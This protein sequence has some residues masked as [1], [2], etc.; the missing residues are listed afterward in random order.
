M[1]GKPVVWT[2]TTMDRF[3]LP[4]IVADSGIELERLAGVSRNSIHE[5]ICRTKRG[6]WRCRYHR[7]EVDDDEEEE[8]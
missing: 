8:S 5:Q 4:L 3:E 1:M 2:M 6:G 7:I